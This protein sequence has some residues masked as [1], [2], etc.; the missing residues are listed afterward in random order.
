L[1][2]EPRFEGLGGRGGCSSTMLFHIS[3]NKQDNH[4]KKKTQRRG[5]VRDSDIGVRAEL[6]MGTRFLIQRKSQNMSLAEE[7]RGSRGE[8]ASKN[9]K[10]LSRGLIY[11]Q[12]NWRNPSIANVSKKKLENNLLNLGRILAKPPEKGVVHSSLA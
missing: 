11:S 8:K 3:F 7:D 9:R 6:T 4:L 5:D 10:P 2:R 12:R 1:D